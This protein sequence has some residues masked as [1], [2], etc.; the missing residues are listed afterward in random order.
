MMS[1]LEGESVEE[2]APLC[3]EEDGHL[4]VSGLGPMIN[5]GT[6]SVAV[7]LGNVVKIIS[8]GH[9]RFGDDD[10]ELQTDFI[11]RGKRRSGRKASSDR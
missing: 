9:A 3:P 4:F 6:S 10:M 11:A 5:V 8:V 7:A 2:T 1:H